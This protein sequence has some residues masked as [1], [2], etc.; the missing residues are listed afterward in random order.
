MTLNNKNNSP[1][2]SGK[3]SEGKKPLQDNGILIG[4]TFYLIIGLFVVWYSQT[5]QAFLIRNRWPLGIALLIFFVVGGIALYRA[6][7]KRQTALVI[8]VAIPILLTLAVAFWWIPDAYHVPILRSVFL[9]IVC[10][11]PAMLYY[12]FIV[13]RKTSLIQEY[14]STLSRLGFFGRLPRSGSNG[15]SSEQEFEWER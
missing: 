1:D 4:T 5:V 9:L 10:F 3:D 6:S 15:Q 2:S 11:L 7:E 8:F 13:S 14:F 12:L